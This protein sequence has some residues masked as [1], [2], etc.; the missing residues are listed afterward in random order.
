MGPWVSFQ[1]GK[2]RPPEGL[3][4]VLG[5]AGGEPPQWLVLISLLAHLQVTRRPS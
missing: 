3:L 1:K 5:E 4:Q 2:N